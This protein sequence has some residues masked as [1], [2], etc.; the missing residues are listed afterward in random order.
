MIE[1]IFNKDPYYFRV[2][3]FLFVPYMIYNLITELIVFG[4]S[5]T[6]Y[7]GIIQLSGYPQLLHN[8]LIQLISLFYLLLMYFSF[9]NNNYNHYL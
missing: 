1:Y 3:L 2:Q 7:L 8:P 5:V 9:N 6:R 4:Y